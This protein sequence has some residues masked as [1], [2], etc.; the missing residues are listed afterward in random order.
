MGIM[1]KTVKFFIIGFIIGVIIS[2]V[3]IDEKFDTIPKQILAGGITIWKIIYF[4]ILI[5]TLP[6]LAIE[7]L[8]KHFTPYQYIPFS[9]MAGHGVAF[10]SAILIMIILQTFNLI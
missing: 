5:I 1:D 10:L 9:F 7:P 3:P 8:K 2:L 6:F 4:S